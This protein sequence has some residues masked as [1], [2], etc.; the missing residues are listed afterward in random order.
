[1][2]MQ[3]S[4]LQR[5]VY[6]LGLL[7]CYQ[8]EG[9]NYYDTREVFDR[10][11]FARDVRRNV[12]PEDWLF[13]KPRYLL[14][15]HGIVQFAFR[16]NV[17]KLIDKFML[18]LD[19]PLIQEMPTMPYLPRPDAVIPAIPSVPSATH[20]MKYETPSAAED[21]LNPNTPAD[22][23]STWETFEV[24]VARPPQSMGYQ[25]PVQ[26]NASYPSSRPYAPQPLPIQSI[27]QSPSP[28]L[29]QQQPYLS[30]FLS[31]DEPYYP[32]PGDMGKLKRKEMAMDE[33]E[34]NIPPNKRLRT[35]ESLFFAQSPYT[36]QSPAYPAY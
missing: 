34:M 10:H 6:E 20:Q 18:V 17:N 21:S 8:F 31:L 24:P 11:N 27:P 3:Q 13:L 28:S 23:N 36:A 16:K 32:A 30:T 29:Q 33:S 5:A 1:M 15:E 14:T 4:Y 25:S 7:P 12:K 35:E 2:Q 22:Y 9:K 26:S 19:R